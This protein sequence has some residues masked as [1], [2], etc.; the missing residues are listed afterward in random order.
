MT[1]FN[2][3]TWTSIAVNKVAISKIKVLNMSREGKGETFCSTNK[4]KG[5]ASKRH[6]LI[7]IL[8]KIYCILCIV[9]P[10]YKVKK[11][12]TLLKQ[13]DSWNALKISSLLTGA[14]LQASVIYIFSVVD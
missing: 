1:L 8:K 10:M 12:I 4:I 5:P 3:Y 13:S 7:I 11:D 6:K 14:D 2:S 9:V